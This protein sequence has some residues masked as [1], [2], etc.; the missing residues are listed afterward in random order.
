MRTAT[1]VPLELAENIKNG[2]NGEDVMTCLKGDLLEGR[3]RRRRRM[4]VHIPDLLMPRAVVVSCIITCG[5]FACCY[6][7][8]R[9]CIAGL[10]RA[11]ASS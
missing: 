4:S 9:W 8:Q 11:S 6:Y 10:L 7:L 2:I 1:S 5:L 3:D